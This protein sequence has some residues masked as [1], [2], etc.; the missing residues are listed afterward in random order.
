VQGRGGVRI[1]AVHEWEFEQYA[2]S[3]HRLAI[4]GHDDIRIY[5]LANGRPLTT[6]DTTGL[7]VDRLTLDDDTI[8]VLGTSDG[9]QQLVAY[10]AANGRRL[11]SAATA[12][13]RA[14]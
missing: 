6:I 5:N 4:V 9:R 11:Q 12:G 2:A 3:R 14:A 13:R 1:I 8:A 7:R 10:D